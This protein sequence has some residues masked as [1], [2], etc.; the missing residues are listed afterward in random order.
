MRLIHA[1]LRPDR[2]FTLIEVMVALAILAVGML[3]MAVL[4]LE[5]L[6]ASRAASERTQAVNL[7]SEIVERMRANRAAGVAYDTETGTPEPRFAAAC[8]SRADGCDPATLAGH[9]LR[10]WLDAVSAAL[11][12]GVGAVRVDHPS[13]GLDRWTISLTWTRGDEAESDRYALVMDL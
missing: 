11:P 4:L 12:G 7:A 6:R 10:G 2:G 13:G 9:D 5:S 1:P 8:E 3:G